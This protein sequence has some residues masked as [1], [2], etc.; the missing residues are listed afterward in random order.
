MNLRTLR[1]FLIST[2][3]VSWGIGM[4]LSAFPDRAEALFGPMGYTN[5]AFILIVYTPGIVAVVLVVRHYGIR[6]LGRF[7]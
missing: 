6:G 5:A 1:T 2:F 3:V 7:L 4:L